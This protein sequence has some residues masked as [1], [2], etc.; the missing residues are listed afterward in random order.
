MKTYNRLT[1]PNGMNLS[2]SMSNP[3]SRANL[4]LDYLRLGGP[5]TKVEILRDVFNRKIGNGC[6]D[7]VTRGWGGYL[8][9][10][11]QTH[12]YIRRVRIGNTVRYEVV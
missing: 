8:F 10:L 5:A 11:L 3:N 1:A 7:T 12:G 9:V 6:G 2:K 4:V